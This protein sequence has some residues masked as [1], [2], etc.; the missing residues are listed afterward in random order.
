MKDL[1]YQ[2]VTKSCRAFETTKKLESQTV[3]LSFCTG[4]ICE[5]GSFDHESLD[6]EV[7][8]VVK[9]VK[10]TTRAHDF[11]L[12]DKKCYLRVHDFDPAK[13]CADKK[14]LYKKEMPEDWCSD[15]KDNPSPL[16]FCKVDSPSTPPHPVQGKASPSPHPPPPPSS[17]EEKETSLKDHLRN[18]ISGAIH[19]W[20]GGKRESD[21]ASYERDYMR[22]HAPQQAP[23]QQYAAQPA[24][25]PQQYAAQPAPPPQQYAAQPPPQYATTQQTYPYYGAQQQVTAQQ[26]QVQNTLDN[27]FE[28]TDN[29]IQK[30]G[31]AA[32]SILSLFN[33]AKQATQSY[34]QNLYQTASTAA[35]QIT[36]QQQPYYDYSGY[37]YNG[38]QQQQQ[39]QAYNS[40]NQLQP[41][42]S[43]EEACRRSGKCSRLE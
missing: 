34:G 41:M 43:Q 27:A 19:A 15:L 22:R 26:Q 17:Q 2:P 42:P 7:T 35:P 9:L 28:T 11:F 4:N 31:N 30:V 18:H 25:P 36:S 1:C 33:Q 40:G 37:Y 8:D 20:S 3:P 24:P 29:T 13:K 38:G 39:R 6:K 21:Q 14:V 23:Q 32:N 5:K 10:P 12:E 16:T